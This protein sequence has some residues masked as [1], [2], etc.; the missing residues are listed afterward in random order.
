MT[1]PATIIVEQGVVELLGDLPNLV[2]VPRLRL[3]WY[4]RGRR[5][6]PLDP[7]TVLDTLAA[8]PTPAVVLARGPSADPG[9]RCLLDFAPLL[10]FDLRRL[11]DCVDMAAMSVS[12]ASRGHEPGSMAGGRV[13]DVLCCGSALTTRRSALSDRP[14]RPTA[15]RR[16]AS[17]AWRPCPWCPAGGLAGARCARCGSPV[18]GGDRG[19]GR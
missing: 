7:E 6:A 3:P 5:W 9:A 10:G 11:P 13:L 16:W 14:L 4:R 1:T 8:V 15:L 18:G 2:V 17:C 12:I 19:G